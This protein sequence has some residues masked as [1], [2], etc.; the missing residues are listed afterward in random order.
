MYV[1]C[2]GGV[3]LLFLAPE[4]FLSEELGPVT[5][6]RA[7]P[8]PGYAEDWVKFNLF[9]FFSHINLQFHRATSKVFLFLF[10]SLEC[11][12]SPMSLGD[13]AI[14][15]V[16]HASPFSQWHWPA[17]HC[18]HWGYCGQHGKQDLRALEKA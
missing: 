12:L 5:V 4:L 16:L 13:M 17:G 2:G 11:P 6:I 18:I 3:G 14:D 10:L 15:S 9:F 1:G 8:S 7:P